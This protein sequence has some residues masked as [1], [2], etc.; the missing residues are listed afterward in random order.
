MTVTPATLVASPSDGPPPFV[1][2]GEVLTRATTAGYVEEEWFAS[3]HDDAGRPYTTQLVVRRPADP[4]RFSGTVIVESLHAHRIA[5]IYMYSSPYILREGHGW[6][7][8]VSQKVALEAH[9]IPTDP[10][11]YASLHIGADPRPAGAPDDITLPPT[12]NDDADLRARWWAELAR[13]NQASSAILAQVGAALRGSGGPFGQHPVPHMVL[14]GHSQTGFVVTNYIRDAHDAHRFANGA[15]VYDGL[16]PS[17]YPAAP[18]GPCDVPIVQ[19]L[20]DGDVSNPDATFAP[21]YEHRQYRRP[22]G[23][24]P[25]DRFRLYELAGVPHMGTR[26]SPF[27]DPHVWQ[28]VGNAGTI[29]LDARMNSLPHNELFNVALH[30]LVQWVAAGLVPP[31]AERLEVGPDGFFA[32]DEQGN[33]CGGVRCVQLDVP[34]ATYFPNPPNPDGSPGLGTVSIEA[35]FDA[36]AMT[37]LYGDHAGYVERFD[38]RLDELI[39]Q[40]WLLA[41]DAPGMRDEARSR[42][43]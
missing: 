5:P 6:A 14:V 3:G 2:A 22:D 40:G 21:D 29:P 34:S 24:E 23:D 11:R 17:G 12:W 30:H 19:V 43:W 33:T 37:R 8:V 26:H 28:Q 25:G 35:P 4:E 7:C 39:A 18:F 31:R 16:F 15:P 32:K 36:A 27:D 13:A 9:V 38:R 41:A 10:E 1:P 20:S 42:Q